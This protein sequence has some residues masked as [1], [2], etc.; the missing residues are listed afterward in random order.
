MLHAIYL[1]FFIMMPKRVLLIGLVGLV[2]SYVGY[3]K[4]KWDIRW[5]VV[6]KFVCE[7]NLPSNIQPHLYEAKFSV[8][9]YHPISCY[10]GRNNQQIHCKNKRD[11]LFDYNQTQVVKPVLSKN[12]CPEDTNLWCDGD[13]KTD[14]QYKSCEAAY[15]VFRNHRNPEGLLLVCLMFCLFPIWIIFETTHN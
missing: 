7:H 10:R 11:F 4:M 3:I 1:P 9:Y 12:G 13:A 14:F 15:K 2:M 5:Q 6:S 8:Y